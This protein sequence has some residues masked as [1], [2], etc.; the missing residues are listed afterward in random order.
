MKYVPYIAI[1]FGIAVAVLVV[2]AAE[3]WWSVDRYQKQ[4]AEQNKTPQNSENLLYIALGD[5]AA[6]GV[7][8]SQRK[9]SYVSRLGSKLSEEYKRPSQV[10]NLSVSGAK[11]QDVIDTQV[12]QLS[13]YTIGEG[14]I[15]TI[16]IGTNDVTR[17]AARSPEFAEQLDTLFAKLPK[18]TVVAD[19]PYLGKSRYQSKN[20]DIVFANQVLR[21]K[22]QKYGLR[23]AP[24]YEN[25]QK[26]NSWFVYSGDFFHPSDY[27]YSI[28]FDSFWQILLTDA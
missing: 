21:E 8:A 22:A 28:W 13:N 4:W 23:V 18:Q 17:G 15:V 9:Y 25:L 24:L 26:K 12:P 1:V 5:S 11:I 2:R 10:I 7:G 27:G 6:Q 19:L 20:N 16:D 14:A 3:V